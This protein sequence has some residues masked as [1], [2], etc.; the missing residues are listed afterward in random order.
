MEDMADQPAPPP[1]PEESSGSPSG[2]AAPPPAGATEP[3]P[4]ATGASYP[5]PTGAA[6]PGG[7]W[8]AGPGGQGAPSGP[9]AGQ[10]PGWAGTAT[11]A[12]PRPPG[13]T[14]RLWGEATATTGSRLALVA[15]AVLAVIVLVIGVGLVGSWVVHRI[16]R[17]GLLE[18]SDDHG[19]WGDEMGPN[20]DGMTPHGNN[21]RGNGNGNGRLQGG[22]QGQGNGRGLGPGGDDDVPGLGVPGLGTL[23]HGEFTT[24]LTGSPTVMVFQTGEVTA[25]TARESLT[26]RSTDGYEATYVLDAS[27]TTRGTPV[28]G[29]QVRVV[30][31]K[32]G[33]KAVLVAAT[34]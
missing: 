26:V 6:P 27:T 3:L 7:G 17:V 29:R 9:G 13:T 31:A 21:G 23:L 25:Y 11:A 24:T 34:G 5:P 2:Q 1:P 19:R 16:D 8:T 10:G 20:R 18:G 30:A 15:A 4:P 22:P 32:D 33:M 14:R 12:A 28:E